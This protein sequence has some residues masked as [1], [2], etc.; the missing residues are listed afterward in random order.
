VSVC[1]STLQRHNTEK[2]VTNIAKKKE[3]RGL[4]PNFHIHVFVSDLYITTIDQ[5]I[6]LQENMWTILGIYKSLTD[7]SCMWQL[8]LRPRNSPFWEYING[9]SVA[10][11]SLS[12]K[13]IYLISQSSNRK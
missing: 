8:G 11:H 4:S 10:G 1:W 5:P 9:I 13:E 2:F 12:K 6:L 7:D 3:L